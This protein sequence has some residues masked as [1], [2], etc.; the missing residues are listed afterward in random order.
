MYAYLVCWQTLKNLK[1]LSRKKINNKI[2][3]IFETGRKNY[4]TH[5]VNEFTASG[6]HLF[7]NSSDFH[8]CNR[9]YT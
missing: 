3:T 4:F 9:L 6:I 1:T 8:G 2:P 5:S 7:T